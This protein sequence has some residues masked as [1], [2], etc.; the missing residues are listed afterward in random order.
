M[1]TRRDSIRLAVL[2][3]LA[4]SGLS[5]CGS[6]PEPV[7]NTGSDVASSDLPRRPAQIGVVPEVAA[8]L[9]DFAGRLFGKAEATGNLVLSPYSVAMAL[10]MCVNGARGRTR[11]E[12]LDV[13][14]VDDLGSL[15]AG[16]NT[17]T[18]HL[19]SLAGPVRRSDTTEG[20]IALDSANSLWGQRGT[21]WRK[22]FLDDLARDYGSGMRQVDYRNASEQARVAINDWVEDRTHDRIRELIKPGLVGPGT[23]LVLVNAIYLKAPWDVPFDEE[24]TEDQPFDGGRLTVP[25]MSLVAMT[26]MHRTGDGWQAATIEYAGRELAMTIVLPDPDRLATIEATVASEGVER[27]VTG[28]RS[29]SLDLQLPK[30]TTRWDAD[31]GPALVALGMPTAFDSSAD[32]SAMSAEE[33]FAIGAVIHQAFID[34]DEA[35]TEAAAATAVIMLGGAMMT[36]AATPFIVDRPFLYVVH[37]TAHGTPLFMGRVVDPAAG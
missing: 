22:P 9:N 34:V 10:A 13:L 16:L 27:F 24:N 36:A 5:A 11:R 18:Q 31:L 23:R 17:L 28:G 19:E 2:S 30:W 15:N 20:E 3:A 14:G 21:A 4:V 29:T 32:F 1:L 25:M 12:M 33:Q 26:A 6:G 37:D 35:G 8:G 7:S